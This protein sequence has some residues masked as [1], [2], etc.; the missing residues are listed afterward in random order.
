MQFLL[1][2]N[3]QVR[4]PMLIHREK[5]GGEPVNYLLDNLLITRDFLGHKDERTPVSHPALSERA[6][7]R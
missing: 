2:E 1:R 6:C 3:P 4:G 5:S 7:R